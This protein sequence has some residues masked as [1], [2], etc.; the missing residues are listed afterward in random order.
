[1]PD[2]SKASIVNLVVNQLKQTNPELVP[3]DG[4][5]MDAVRQARVPAEHKR[6]IL[7]LVWR[8]AGPAPLLSIGQGIRSIQYDPIWYSAIHSA[9]PTTLFDKWRRYE[10]FAHSH[11]RLRIDQIGES[12]ASF[13]RHTVTGGTPTAPENLLICGVVIALLEE[14]GCLGLR[15]EMPFEDGRLYLIREN[16][17]FCIPNDLG[18]LMTASWT[19]E[20]QSFS[21]RVK[22]TASATE[23]PEIPLPRPCD[24]TLRASIESVVQLLMLDI[25]RQWKVGE[26]AREAGLSTRSLQRKLGDADLDFS[27]LVRLV[28]IHEACRLLRA[29]DAPITSIGFCTGF[30]DSAHFSRDFRASM[31][32]TPSDYRSLS[33]SK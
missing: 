25:A 6:N 4:G 16:G 27:H 32:M 3:M 17:R 31:N 12:C 14:I 15:C 21:S 8:K 19:I 23:L 33:L 7:D 10:V 9:N 11:N 20:W 24:S 22:N 13:Q 2:F 28:R 30:S 26:L 18:M 5:A 29:G 1:M